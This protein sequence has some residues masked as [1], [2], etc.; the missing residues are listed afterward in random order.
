[1]AIAE[2]RKVILV[3]QKELRE[4]LIKK[5]GEK[6]IF[7]PVAP[8]QE[9]NSSFFKPSQV[10]LTS[11]QTN[12]AKLETAINFLGKFEDKKFDLGL[13]PA[14][15]VVRPEQFYSWTKNFPWEDICRECAEM[16]REFERI[17]EK[18]LEL[19]EEYAAVLPWRKITFPLEKLRALKY[20][21]FQAAIFSADLKDRI[22]KKTQDEAIFVK[23]FE[24]AQRKLYTL[25]IFL[26]EKKDSVEKIIQEFRGEKVKLREDIAYSLRIKKIREEE[27]E[28]EKQKGKI[29]EKVKKTVPERI[30]L[31]VIYDYFY[32]LLKENQVQAV[33][34]LSRFT[35]YLEG[36]VKKDDISLLQ[37]AISEFPQVT[38]IVK[39]PGSK[40]KSQTPVALTNRKV[41]KPFELVTELYGLPRYLEIDPT[42]FLAPFFALFLALCLTDGGYG[43]LL[44]IFSFLI[45]RKMQVGEG[46]KKLFSM[47]FISGIVTIV[48]GTVTGGIFGV[49]LQK[50]PAFLSPLKKLA[51]FN[52]MQ[53]PMIFLVIALAIGVVHLLTGII[54]EMVDNLRHKNIATA[55]L[56]QFSWIVVILGLVLIALPYGKN[57][58]SQGSAGGETSLPLT[59]SP[60]Q[61]FLV[62]K[63]MPL[64]SQAG[65]FMAVA[66]IITLFLFKGRRSRN[67]AKRLAKGAYEVYGI[68]QLFADVLSYSRLLALGLATSVIATVVN[69]IASMAGATPFV[70]PVMAV[71]I[72]ILGHIGNLLINTLSG[73]IHTARLQFVEF[74]TKFYEGGGRKFE[75]LKKE[76]K[77]TIIM[78]RME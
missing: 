41:F 62:L 74:F 23:I 11:L 67:I 37:K 34:G 49:E 76:G 70:G 60:S 57:F 73:F 15:V 64:Y 1:M 66:G 56:D 7:Q 24:E 45:P 6:G 75:P 78:D 68:I 59:L 42:P 2:M 40:E 17:K 61:I 46:G 55:F 77:Y 14:R 32:D 72:L 65:F 21:D 5:L 47:L 12:L 44:A 20:L 13:F 18:V 16:E 29:L 71:V 48:T 69:T 52:P 3:G 51:L 27:K 35:F 10:K 38:A 53:Q 63:G 28:L 43:I 19:R 39:K 9:E 30:K 58:I 36:W 25:F 8:S 54:L 26:K 33:T 50:M 4:K 31:M 22:L